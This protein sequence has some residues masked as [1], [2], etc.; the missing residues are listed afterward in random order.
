[1]KIVYAVQYY[2]PHTGG[3][4]KV[5][6]KLAESAAD[7]GHEVHVITFALPGMQ[8]ATTEEGGVTVHRVR[9]WHFFDRV[10]GI[11]FC[12]GGLGVWRT[13]RQLVSGAD[14]VHLHDVFY[15]TSLAAYLAARRY[16]KP[17]VLTQHVAMVAH[18]SL[19]MLAEKLVYGLW[20]TRIFHAARRIVTYQRVVADFVRGQGVPAEQVLEVHNGIETDR[21]APISG[22]ERSKRR[23]EFSLPQE[24]PLVL[25]VG[26]FVPKKGYAEL[27]E[28]RSDAYDLVFVGSGAVPEAWHTTP[29]VHVLGECTQDEVAALMPAVDVFA[30]PSRGE[31]WTLSMQEAMACGLPLVAGDAPE[32]EAYELDRTRIVLCEPTPG[33]LKAELTR[34][35]SD[36]ALRERMGAYS[37]ELAERYFDW[38]KNVQDVLALYATTSMN[39]EPCS[40]FPVVVTSWDD[41]HVLDMKLA[42]LLDMYGVR[43]TFYV[44]PEDHELAPEERLAHEQIRVLGE[45]HEI[46]AHTVHHQ[47]LTTLGDAEAGYEIAESK[48]VLEDVL[49]KP[50][51]SFCYPAGKYAARHVRMVREAGFLN[52]RTVRRFVTKIDT[53]VFELGT[54]IHTYDH[55]LDVWGV[56][57]LARYNPFRFFYLYRRWDRQAKALF[58][59]AQQTGGVFHLW[60]HS[61]E[62][63]RHGDW[64]RLEEVLQYIGGRK[65]VRYCTVS[66][67]TST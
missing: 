2:P 65:G 66:E 60:G 43:G 35:C 17:L 48:R 63:D 25:F 28:A 27:F 40:P 8:P 51:T 33:S 10:F 53:N 26:R 19:V 36:P 37:R 9:G 20:G 50:V 23:A 1:M 34:V 5:A 64:E 14:V 32:Y 54:S 13:M 7:A 42:A 31:M 4:E 49:Q 55:W 21:F 39:P 22:E 18:G 6:K 30:A 62:V 45:T 12:V 59:Q 38:E 52:A 58:D 16:R 61:E 46:G 41:G 56:F 24:K 67:S 44:A 57:T 47:H 29:G 15:L 3:L 11:P